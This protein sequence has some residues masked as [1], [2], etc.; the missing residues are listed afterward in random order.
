MSHSGS[1]LILRVGAT[2]LYNESQHSIW[3]F[4]RMALPEYRLRRYQLGWLEVVKTPQ[5]WEFRESWDI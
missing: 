4:Y 1:W 3:S 2:V 5:E